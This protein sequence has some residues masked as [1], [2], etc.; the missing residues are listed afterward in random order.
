M[1][2]TIWYHTSLCTDN[3][4][5]RPFDIAQASWIPAFG[6]NT[7]SWRESEGTGESDATPPTTINDIDFVVSGCKLG[8][9]VI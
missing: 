4:I 3:R 2:V 6:R 1:A 8:G 5:R 7:V 9:E